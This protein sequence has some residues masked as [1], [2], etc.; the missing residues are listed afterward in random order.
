MHCSGVQPVVDAP[1]PKGSWFSYDYWRTWWR[2][3]SGWRDGQQLVRLAVAE[4]DSFD[5]A[6]GVADL[7][8]TDR[9]DPQ[10]GLIITEV[11]PCPQFDR[12]AIE[13]SFHFA[14][15]L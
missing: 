15:C 14:I 3:W 6:R 4:H 2:Y 13:C 1:R 12:S 9:P 7:R 11:G 10:S 5:A 8:F